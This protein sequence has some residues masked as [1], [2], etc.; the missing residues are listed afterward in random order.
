MWGG[1]LKKTTPYQG[2]HVMLARIP[3][4][5]WLMIILITLYV[6]YNPWGFSLFHMWASGNVMDLLPFKVLATLVPMALM[7]L[8]IHGTASSTSWLGLTVMM[9][10]MA[11]GL[12]S[13]HALLS[14]DLLSMHLWSWLT[15]PLAALVLTVGWQWPRIWRRSTGAVS[16]NDPDTPV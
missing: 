13:A 3:F 10:I 7:G 5:G 9:L 1:L 14:F 15:Q 16:V 2:E 6:I 11:T 8:V 4:W 12:W